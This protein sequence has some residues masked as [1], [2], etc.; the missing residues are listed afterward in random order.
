MPESLLPPT[1]M[2]RTVC[3]RVFGSSSAYLLNTCK[4]TPPRFCGQWQ[5]SQVFREG[6]NRWLSSAEGIG[7]R[8][9]LNTVSI[10]WRVP[11]VLLLIQPAAPGATWHSTHSTLE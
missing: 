2:S 11:F 5:F 9:V 8:Y 7:R 1:I 10:S 6:I 3:D 4:R